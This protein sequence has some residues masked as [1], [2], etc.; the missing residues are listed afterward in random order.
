MNSEND[1]MQFI[2]SGRIEDYLAY[3]GCM[4]VQDYENEMNIPGEH[5]YAGDVF[6]DGHGNQ[7]KP[8]GRV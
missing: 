8:G 6:C 2:K 7:P 4:K 1:W 5:P 3:I